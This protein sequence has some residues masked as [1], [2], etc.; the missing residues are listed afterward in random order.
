[1][2]TDLV[3]VFV[4]GAVDTTHFSSVIVYGKQS[5]GKFFILIQ[6]SEDCGRLD[7]F[8]KMTTHSDGI[9]VLLHLVVRTLL[10]I[11]TSS[12]TGSPKLFP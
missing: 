11:I 3:P 7:V 12:G 4:S 10:P 6:S 9:P 1:M 5:P 2:L 8:E